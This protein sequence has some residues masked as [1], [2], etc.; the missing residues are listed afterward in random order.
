MGMR[1]SCCVYL[2]WQRSPRWTP[3]SDMGL[4][5]ANRKTATGSRQRLEKHFLFIFILKDLIYF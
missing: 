2:L 1:S 4:A 5:L 3:G